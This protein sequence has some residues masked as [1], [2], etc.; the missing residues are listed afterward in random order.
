VCIGPVT[1]RT[2]IRLCRAFWVRPTSADPKED[3]KLAALHPEYQALTIIHEASHLTHDNEVERG[4]TIAVPECLTQLVAV[5]NGIP[6]DMNFS[7]FCLQSRVC[8]PAEDCPGV[9]SAQFGFAAPSRTRMVRTVF[10]T[11]FAVPLKGRLSKWIKQR[12]A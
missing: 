5:A 11:R 1:P 2:I 6:I 8:G 7:S 12:A 3:A 4:H 10:N 9:E